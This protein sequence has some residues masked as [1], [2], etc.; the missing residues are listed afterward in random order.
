MRA[1]PLIIVLFVHS[2]DR[3]YSIFRFFPP[4]K[5]RKYGVK[6]T[7]QALLLFSQCTMLWFQDKTGIKASWI[8]AGRYDFKLSCVSLLQV[9]VCNRQLYSTKF[10]TEIYTF[11]WLWVYIVDKTWLVKRN[12][13]LLF[14]IFCLLKPQWEEVIHFDKIMAGWHSI[15]LM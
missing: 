14:R 3:A 5:Y 12:L 8:L 2:V 6:S 10:R 13:R 1:E 9:Q 7:K 11:L 15:C 4:Q